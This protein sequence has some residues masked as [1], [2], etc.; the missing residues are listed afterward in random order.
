MNIIAI[1]LTKYHLYFLTKTLPQLS[2]ERCTLVVFDKSLS[3]FN[4]KNVEVKLFQYEF[5]RSISHAR[6]SKKSLTEFANSALSKRY[7]KLLISND[8][9]FRVQILLN[10]INFK[11][12]YLFEDGLASYIPTKFKKEMIFRLLFYRFTLGLSKVNITGIGHSKN[13]KGYYCFS[14][15]AF[16]WAENSKKI[17]LSQK[18]VDQRNKTSSST[19]LFIGQPFIEDQLFSDKCYFSLVEKAFKSQIDIKERIY[20]QHPRESDVIT[21]RI[22]R[23]M[24]VR[25]LDTTIKKLDGIIE[26]EVENLPY[27]PSLIVGIS[28][29]ALLNLY[30]QTNYKIKIIDCT[31][32]TRNHSILNSQKILRNSGIEA[33]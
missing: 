10:Q 27:K 19:I 30:N 3:N 24:K 1:A 15:D 29:T 23:E 11:N 25:G 16:P 12:L 33:E 13:V 28:S 21:Q 32:I 9:D 26:E 17:I 22:K 18:H 5:K 7:E 4:H 8:L 2:F 31:D 14:I 20:I 6:R